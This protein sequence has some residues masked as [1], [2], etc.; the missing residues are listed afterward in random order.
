MNIHNINLNQ[1]HLE[2]VRD[3]LKVHQKS[4][5][6]IGDTILVLEDE[7]RILVS[8]HN[9]TYLLQYLDRLI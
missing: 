9:K 3:V 2:E 7:T 1:K 6:E 4:I 5:A 8:F